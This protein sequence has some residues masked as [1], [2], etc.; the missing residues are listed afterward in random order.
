MT[1]EHIPV[2]QGRVVELL[3]R[4]PSGWILDATVGLGGHAQ[5]ILE[6]IPESRLV[7]LDVDP[8]ALDAAAKRLR[9]FGDRVRLVRAGFERMDACLAELQIKKVGGIVIDLGISSLQIDAALRG[10]SYRHEGPLDMRMDPESQRKAADLINAAPEKEIEEVLR[11]YGEERAARRI[12]RAIV[13]RRRRAPLRTTTDLA[14]VV[15]SCSTGR[16]PVS[17]LARVFQGVRMWVNGELENIQQALRRSLGVLA[18]GSVL[19]VLSYHSLEDRMTK[20]FFRRQV[21]GCVCPPD[22]PRCGCGFVAGFRLLTRRAVRPSAAEI[23]ANVRARSA[24]LRALQ[25]VE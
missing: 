11:R 19:V 12:A 13:K 14:A 1:Y 8:H 18:P 10:F 3:A 17:A 22:L 21:E 5:A 6:G 4:G 25:R 7:G 15:R 16:R 20:Q 24:R 9:R 2:L 23:D